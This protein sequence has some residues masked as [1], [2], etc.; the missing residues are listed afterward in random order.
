MR[1]IWITAIIILLLFITVGRSDATLKNQ[2]GEGRRYYWNQLYEMPQWQTQQG[3]VPQQNLMQPQSVGW[4][5]QQGGGWALPPG[6]MPIPGWV[7]SSMQPTRPPFLWTLFDDRNVCTLDAS[8]LVVLENDESTAS[9]GLNVNA[10]PPPSYY[11]GDLSSNAVRM[12][13]A[14]IATTSTQACTSCCKMSCKHYAISTG[15]VH[16][17]LINSTRLIAGQFPDITL[18]QFQQMKRGGSI[19]PLTLSPL[20]PISCV[21]CGPRRFFTSWS[22]SV[23]N[24]PSQS[25]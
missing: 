23:P 1:S 18:P 17:F 8:I 6:G 14:N 5:P 21:C 4:A 13:C 3:W 10:Q 2:T 25:I 16:G 12:S 20:P 9:A 15:D 24:P 11:G 7:P 22:P 19:P